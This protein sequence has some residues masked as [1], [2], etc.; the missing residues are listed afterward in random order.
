MEKSKCPECGSQNLIRDD[1]SGEI[2]CGDCGFITGKIIDRG[3]DWRAFTSEERESRP[4]AGRPTTY[5]I[6]DKGLSTTIDPWDVDASGKVLPFLTRPQIWRLRKWQIRLRI[7]SAI[8]RNLAQAMADLER[9]SDKHAIP[10]FTREEAAVIYRKA[11]EK[12]LVRG[13]NIETMVAAALYAACRITRIFR[14]LDEISEGNKVHKKEIARD[15][16]LLVRELSLQIPIVDAVTYISKI[17]SLVGI[18]GESQGLA[19]RI[20]QEARKKRIPDGKD[21]IGLAA[22]TLYIACLQKGEEV[23]QKTLAEAAGVTEVT[24]RNRYKQLK[25]ELNLK[26]PYPP[27]RWR[28]P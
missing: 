13:R 2:V 20:L 23:R 16:R 4:R 26:L 9:L 24:V 17:A 15:Y 8:E 14:T 22:A 25:K 6:H 7:Q 18:S 1:D 12:S 21:P 27:Q 3:P 19:I 11:L 10:R 5:S 28:N